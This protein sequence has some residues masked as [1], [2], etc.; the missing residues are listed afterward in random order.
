MALNNA[1]N[2]LA[3]RNLC[4]IW[5]IASCTLQAPSRWHN[6]WKSR[7]IENPT[8]NALSTIQPF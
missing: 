1:A 4:G 3:Q 6:H 2:L 5:R 8:A 7:Q